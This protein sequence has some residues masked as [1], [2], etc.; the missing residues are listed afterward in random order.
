MSNYEILRDA[1]NG[2]RNVSFVYDGLH[3]ECSP[4]A[5]GG[6]K[7]KLNCL[8][9]Q[10]AGQTSKGPI[11]G[12]AVNNW[13]CLDIAKIDDLRVIDGEWHSFENH[14]RPAT[15]IDDMQVEVEY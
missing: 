15:C 14:S 1:I 7:D 9:Y 12:D 3:R 10:F 4:H 13:R 5:L 6:K 2:K 8:V 11:T